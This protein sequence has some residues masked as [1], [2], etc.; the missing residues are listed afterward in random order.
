[1]E[2]QGIMRRSKSSWAS[3]LHIVKKKD[4]TWRPCGDYRQFNLAAKPDLYPPLHIEDLSTKLE[5]M[6]V[7]STIDLRKE[8]WQVPVAAADVPKTAIITLFGLWEFLRMPFGLKNAGQSFQR[9]MDDI[10]AGIPVFIYLDDVLMASPTVA[11][12]K[13]DLQEVMERLQQDGLVIR[14]EKCQLFK[15]QVEF[16]G[17]LVDPSGIRP[18][19]AKVEAITKYPRPSTSSQLLSFLGMIYFYRMYIRGVASILKPLT[20]ATKGGGPNHRKLNWQPDME[21]AFKEAKVALSQAAILAQP[22]IPG[23]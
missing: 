22:A 12:H 6:K 2:Q 19:P 8:Y 23:C 10:L 13:K 4:G 18:L 20:D 21:Q 11:K 3:P 17:H 16:L 15:S 9:F 14:E 7:F 5:G 1:M